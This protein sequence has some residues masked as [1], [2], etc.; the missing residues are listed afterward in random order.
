LFVGADADL[1]VVS[2][3]TPTLVL[4]ALDAE[5]RPARLDEIRVHRSAP[6][7]RVHVQGTLV[8]AALERAGIALVDLADRMAPVVLL[9]RERE[10]KIEWPRSAGSP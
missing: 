10:M 4:V 2:N 6:A 5:G 3:G 7:L 8:S 1:A 9:P